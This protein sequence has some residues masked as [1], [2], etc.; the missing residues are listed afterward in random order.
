MDDEQLRRWVAETLA[1]LGTS[2]FRA[3]FTLS[4]KDRAYALEHGEA[5]V[6]EHARD[7]LAKRVGPAW[8]AKDGKQTPFRGHPVFTAQHATATCCR[9]CIAK[10]HHIPKG[11]PLTDEELDRLS[12]L[13]VRW[14]RRDIVRHDRAARGGGVLAA[15]AGDGDANAVASSGAT[16]PTGAALAGAT[17]AG[18]APADATLTGTAPAGAARNL[19][20]HFL[21][22]PAKIAQLIDAADIREED[23]VAE[24]GA[25]V[26]TV[27]AQVPEEASLTL[28]E[29]DPL[30]CARLRERFAKRGNVR[31]I[32]GDALGFLAGARRGGPTP[33]EPAH[34]APVPDCPAPDGSAPDGPTPGEPTPDVIISNLPAGLTP[35]VLDALAALDFRV[36]IVAA[37]QGEDLTNW[38][39]RLR[40]EAVETLEP[41]DFSPRQPFAS[42]VV[43]ITRQSGRAAKYPI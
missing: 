42:E 16:S 39:D 34:D 10:W 33:D 23:R 37:R 1:R 5:T 9:G 31:V 20:Q 28:V 2:K 14:I 13:V 40:F 18:A 26:G 6:R 30:L 32:R 21:C 38:E 17:L 12:E 41:D 3:N 7:L 35:R 29:L 24:L 22:N 27:A 36:A 8:P 19:D 15:G 25:G 43:R 4:A 11:R